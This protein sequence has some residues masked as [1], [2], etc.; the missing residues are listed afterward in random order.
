[1]LPTWGRFSFLGVWPITCSRKT[2]RGLSHQKQDT[3]TKTICLHVY[4]PLP[5]LVGDSWHVLVS[6]TRGTGA[7]SMTPPARGA[8]SSEPGTCTLVC[9][10][11][12]TRELGVLNLAPASCVWILMCSQRGGVNVGIAPSPCGSCCSQMLEPCLSSVLSP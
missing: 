9:E 3:R 10:L 11:C 12:C 2:R 8:Q 6:G 1:M 4:L 5:Q 7:R